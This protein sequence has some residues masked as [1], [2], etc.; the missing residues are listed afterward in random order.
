M[1]KKFTQSECAEEVLFIETPKRIFCRRC[2]ALITDTTQTIAVGGRQVHRRT[3]PA[4]IEF[5]FQCFSE[6]PGCQREGSYTFEHTWFPGNAWCFLLC[7][8][9]QTHLGW[10]FEGSGNFRALIIDR[11]RYERH[12]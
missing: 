7:G 12:N 11:L 10:H 9:C 6:A 8:Q 2:D 1:F 3:N 5:S 4:N